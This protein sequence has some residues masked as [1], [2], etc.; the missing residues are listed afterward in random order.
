MA[1]VTL[2]AI[3]MASHLPSRRI[4]A[5][6]IQ[7]CQGGYQQFQKNQVPRLFSSQ[8]AVKVTTHTNNDGVDSDNNSNNKFTRLESLRLQLNQEDSSL[9]EFASTEPIIKRK[10]APPRSA[11]I[12]PVSNIL[13]C[14]NYTRN[15]FINGLYCSP[16]PTLT[17]E[18]EMAQGSTGY[19]S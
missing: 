15:A 13:F 10:K 7:A 9:H 5:P 3:S 11:K 2:Y 8:S 4:F 16:L 12:L 17:I 14:I 18:T 1:N 19:I 6:V